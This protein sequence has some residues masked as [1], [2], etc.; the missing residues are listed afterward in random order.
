MDAPV[1]RIS[2]IAAQSVEETQQQVRQ[3]LQVLLMN[4]SQ[5]SEV[6]SAHIVH[7]M[8]VHLADASTV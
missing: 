5:D 7:P 8:E 4:P 1:N 6:I 2:F 3:L